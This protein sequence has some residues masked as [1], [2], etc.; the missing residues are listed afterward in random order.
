MWFSRK[1]LSLDPGQAIEVD[2]MT[3]RLAGEV[4][5]TEITLE[6]RLG[7]AKETKTIA[8]T[9]KPEPAP[10]PSPPPTASEPAK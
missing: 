7:A 9:L 3:S 2:P 5:G 6:L 10:T 1:K 4:T 8:L